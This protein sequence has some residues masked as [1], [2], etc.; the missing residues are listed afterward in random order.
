[1]KR[2]QI[3]VVGVYPYKVLNCSTW[4]DK[5]STISPGGEQFKLTV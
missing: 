4:S 3:L 1:M 5:D 2:M